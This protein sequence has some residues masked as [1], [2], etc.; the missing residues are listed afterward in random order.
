MTA[1]QISLLDKLG[2]HWDANDGKWA[3][4]F[5]QLKRFKEQ[6][7]HFEVE[8]VEGEESELSSWVTVQ[9]NNNTSGNLQANRKAKLDSIG[10]QWI[11]ED[12]T[13]VKWQEMY[14]QLKTYHAEHGDADV[15]AKLKTNPK[16][17]NWVSSQRIQHKTGRLPHEQVR[18]LGE[19]GFSWKQ[20]EVGTWEDRLAEVA[21]FKE[22]NGHCEI[23]LN[24][25]DN[26]KL[27]RFVNSMR[28]QRNS[29]RLAADRIAK[30]D[31]LGFAWGTS[32][33]EEV[34][35]EGITRAWKTR[36]DELLQYKQT[37]G[38]CNVPTEWRENPQLG[39]W[40]SHQRGFWKRGTL[41]P[42]RQRWLDKIGFDW[43]SGDSKDA[44]LI[45]FEQLKAYKQRFGDWHVPR[46]WKENPQ[47][48]MWVALQRHHRN[49]G[50]LSPEREQLLHEIEFK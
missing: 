42:E 1:E 39:H 17:A 30:L 41:H 36:F 49:K 2:F 16:L 40:V 3:E 43:R 5:E 6:H 18:L 38:N 23:P 9:R 44:W 12:K 32:G 24:Y 34:A 48:G 4:R 11:A 20:R 7:G 21:A 46:K 35:G 26:P 10:F 27:G 47:L 19:L 8:Q 45:R 33:R 37:H 15:P 50:C 25:P 28:T 14:E 29:G 22:K 13:E 31:A